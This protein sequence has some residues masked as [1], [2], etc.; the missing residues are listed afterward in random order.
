MLWCG[1]RLNDC[2][3]SESGYVHT[4]ISSAQFGCVAKIRFLPSF[5]CL[6]CSW[7]V[8]MHGGV[9]GVGVGTRCGGIMMRMAT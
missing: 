5:V 6:Y 7:L 9:C 3:V 4:P 8:L 2:R 1:V